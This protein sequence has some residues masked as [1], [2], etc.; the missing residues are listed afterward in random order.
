MGKSVVLKVG[1]GETINLGNFES[2]KIDIG[3]EVSCDEK[4]V[5]AKYEETANWVYDKL[6]IERAMI[7]TAKKEEE[8]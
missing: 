8:G 2:S 1:R 4:D 5:E 3:L 6:E 7:I